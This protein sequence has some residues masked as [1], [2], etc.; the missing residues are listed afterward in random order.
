MHPFTYLQA[1]T[2]EAAIQA[3]SGNAQATFFAGGTTLLDLMKLDVLAPERLVDINRLSLST[4]D[5]GTNKITVGANVRNSDLANH[6]AIREN[7]PV[8]SEAVLAGA[9]AQ[10]RNMATTGGNILQRTRCSYFRDAGSRCN[11]RTPGSGCDAIH[12]INRSHAILGTSDECIATHPSDMCVALI[13][14]DATIQTLL[15]NGQTRFL[16]FDGFHLLP[17]ATP[18][19]ENSLQHGELITHLHLPLAPV[20]RNSH[21]LKVR[22]RASYEFALTSAAVAVS[23]SG[24]KIKEARIGLG[25]IATRPWRSPEAEAAL[26]NQPPS[27]ETFAAA[28]NAALAAAK[29]HEHN[30][31]KVNLAKRTLILALETVTKGKN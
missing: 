17:R 1:S 18:H 20:T 30:A 5:V 27:S 9:S 29:P 15:P 10:L 8:L 22:D 7:F 23:V 25:D 31:F 24:G 11:K 12:G 16:P 19:L 13:M 2:T 21:Y 14:L 3:V 6:P 28:A 4:I 26:L